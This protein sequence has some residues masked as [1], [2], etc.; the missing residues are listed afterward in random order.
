MV[1]IK[2]CQKGVSTGAG[3]VNGLPLE[4]RG[5]LLDP[6]TATEEQ[7]AEQQPPQRAGVR[8]PSVRDWVVDHSQPSA[9]WLVTDVAWYRYALAFPPLPTTTSPLHHNTGTSRMGF[10]RGD[11]S[12]SGCKDGSQYNDWKLRP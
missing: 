11:P 1:Q 12:L 10:P 8:L 6:D 2:G 7:P 9:L 5:E 3:L 4:G